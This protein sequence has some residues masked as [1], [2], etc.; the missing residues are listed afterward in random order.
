MSIFSKSKEQR[1][2]AWESE[3]GLTIADAIAQVLIAYGPQGYVA[4]R[5]RTDDIPH[6]SIRAVAREQLRKLGEE[7]K[8]LREEDYPHLTVA[9]FRNE[10]NKIHKMSDAW[11][12]ARS[13]LVAAAFPFSYIV[14]S[15]SEH[16]GSHRVEYDGDTWEEAMQKARILTETRRVPGYAR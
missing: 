9:E 3:G 13:E 4:I 15:G 6:E 2:P 12:E 5:L 10:Q 14:G 8:F 7:P 11:R 1:R 16:L